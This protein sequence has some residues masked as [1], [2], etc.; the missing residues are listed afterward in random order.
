MREINKRVVTAQQFWQV[1]RNVGGIPYASPATAG[2]L[3]RHRLQIRNNA[4]GPLTMT[5]QISI[6]LLALSTVTM[7]VFLYLFTV[8]NLPGLAAPG[9][10]GVLAASTR[11]SFRLCTRL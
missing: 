11:A 5:R 6:A 2:K 10:T 7:A 1:L 4:K 9:I 8:R 3:L